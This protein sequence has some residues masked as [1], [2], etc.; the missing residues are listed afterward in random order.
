[1]TPLGVSEAPVSSDDCNATAGGASCAPALRPSGDAMKHLGTHEDSYQLLHESNLGTKLIEEWR[2]STMNTIALKTPFPTRCE[3]Q[4]TSE[5]YHA[6]KRYCRRLLGKQ[7]PTLNSSTAQRATTTLS[8]KITTQ[9]L[10]DMRNAST[11]LADHIT[12][13]S[14]KAMVTR[15][16]LQND[17]DQP[18]SM[19]PYDSAAELVDIDTLWHLC[20]SEHSSVQ[21]DRD[22]TMVERQIDCHLIAASMPQYSVPRAMTPQPADEHLEEDLSPSTTKSASRLSVKRLTGT[23]PTKGHIV[24]SR[25]IMSFLA[26]LAYLHGH[27]RISKQVDSTIR[28]FPG[29]DAQKYTPVS[30]I[31]RMTPPLTRATALHRVKPDFSEP[32]WPLGIDASLCY[33]CSS[34]PV[35]DDN[36]TLS[37]STRLRDAGKACQMV[38]QRCWIGEER[39]LMSRTSTP[40][41]TNKHLDKTENKLQALTPI[42]AAR[43][44]CCSNI[45]SSTMT[46]ISQ[47]SGEKSNS[48]QLTRN[49]IIELRPRV[50][51]FLAGQQVTPVSVKEALTSSCS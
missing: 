14:T 36:V 1:M 11:A 18:P 20:I 10:S 2:V 43:R 42:P 44:L 27:E 22:S 8:Q 48:S 5:R 12:A 51:Y 21:Q 45:T 24:E 49:R 16:R 13:R 32:Q 4:G 15:F 17:L 7:G 47:C 38:F 26:Q 37:R 30:K 39:Q 25:S 41:S 50:E 40:Q 19:R 3:E 33:D 6:V 46:L 34:G 29:N 23:R 31:I 35:E 28:K 9:A